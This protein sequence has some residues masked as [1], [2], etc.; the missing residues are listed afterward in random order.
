MAP[1][2]SGTC[3][4]LSGI[5]C[6][7]NCAKS[8]TI[9]KAKAN[10]FP[11]HLTPIGLFAFQISFRGRHCPQKTR[12]HPIKCSCYTRYTGVVPAPD[13]EELLAF[14]GTKSIHEFR[15][16]AL[17]ID[18]YDWITRFYSPRELCPEKGVKPQYLY[19][20]QPMRRVKLLEDEVED[21]VV[22]IKRRVY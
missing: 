17:T 11:K 8:H 6:S 14:G 4:H 10:H 22:L 12:Q 20:M 5:Y 13:K 18:S 16:G 19:T 1:A 2:W 15:A 7:W 21:P 3:Y 9:S